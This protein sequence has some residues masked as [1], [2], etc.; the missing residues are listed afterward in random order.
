MN[1][2]SES[3]RTHLQVMQP[4]RTFFEPF[5]PDCGCEGRVLDAGESESGS[6][7]DG[8]GLGMG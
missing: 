7:L 2:H 3:S 6:I 1:N 4:V 5:L 8:N